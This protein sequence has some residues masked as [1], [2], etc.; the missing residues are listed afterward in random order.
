[1]STNVPDR[2]IV[3][4]IESPK[5]DGKIQKVLAGWYGGYT[6]GDR[7]Q[8]NSGIER[9]EETEDYYD[10]YGYSGSLYRCYKRSYG[11]SA[12]LHNVYNSFLQDMETLGPEYKL[13]VVDKYG[14]NYE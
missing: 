8:L 5:T 1:M 7:W 11:L 6:T 2:W 4:E 14:F 3:L 10:F 12:Y 13:T 9:V